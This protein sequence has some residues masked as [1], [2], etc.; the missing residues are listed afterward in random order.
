MT[1]K[2]AWI[3]DTAAQLDESFIKKHHVH[4]LP[5]SVVFEEAAFKEDIDLTARR[6]LRK[7]KRG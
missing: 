6:V 4:I 5:L 3:T 1:K 2:I 7:I